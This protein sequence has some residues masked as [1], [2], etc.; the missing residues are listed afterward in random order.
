MRDPSPAKAK[1]FQ[2]EV[3]EV[4]QAESND[5]ISCNPPE[6]VLRFDR[7]PLALADV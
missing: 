5:R 3:S 6:E 2:R 7:R 4:I 1:V